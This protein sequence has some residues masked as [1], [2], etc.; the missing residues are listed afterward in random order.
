MIVYG[1]IKRWIGDRGFG[2]VKQDTD[3]QDV[4][5][6]LYTLRESGLRDDIEPGTPVKCEVAVDPDGRLRATWVEVLR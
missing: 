4:F 3:G 1:T 6:H 5:L 2:F